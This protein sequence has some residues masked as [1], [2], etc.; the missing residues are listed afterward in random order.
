[1]IGLG[2]DKDKHNNRMPV[3]FNTKLLYSLEFWTS[4]Y[5]KGVLS[6]YLWGM[7]SLIPR[8]RAGQHNWWFLRSTTILLLMMFS[9]L[10]LLIIIIIINIINIIIIII[11]MAIQGGP[12]ALCGWIGSVQRLLMWNA[13]TESDLR[14]NLITRAS[15]IDTL[16]PQHDS[17]DSISKLIQH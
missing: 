17:R 5:A 11:L 4:V 15:N 10:L 1:M 3:P 8:D 6:S 9:L 16:L 12:E 14:S 7:P 13:A 2:S